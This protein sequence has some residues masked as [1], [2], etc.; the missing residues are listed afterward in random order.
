MIRYVLRKGQKYVHESKMKQ[1]FSFI[2]QHFNNFPRL[3]ST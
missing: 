3:C 2:F 1:P